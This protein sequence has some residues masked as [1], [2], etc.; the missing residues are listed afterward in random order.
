MFDEN[1]DGECSESEADDIGQEES[2]V[3]C[4]CT[5][6]LGGFECLVVGAREVPVE[7]GEVYLVEDESHGWHKN[8]RH[9]GSDNFAESGSDNDADSEVDDIS[10][11]S[12]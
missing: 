6:F 1:E 5:S 12:K 10:F 7:F 4:R 3:E 8:I 11:D 9:K 2:V